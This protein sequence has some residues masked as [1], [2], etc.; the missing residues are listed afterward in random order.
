MAKG[1]EQPGGGGAA[2]TASELAVGF[3]IAQQLMQQGGVVAPAT[4]PAGAMGTL[5]AAAAAA[6]AGRGHRG[7][8]RSAVARGGREGARRLRGRRDDHHHV[9]RAAAKKIGA[10]YRIKR[11]ALQE[12][13]EN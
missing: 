7:T 1:M 5:G 9:G 6:G 12:Y 10:S 4:A 13:L 8:A 2:G 11:A 3:A